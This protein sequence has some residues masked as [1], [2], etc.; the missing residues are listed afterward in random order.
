MKKIYI[1]TNNPIFVK[2][3]WKN[4]KSNLPELY[5]VSYFELNEAGDYVVLVS[6]MNGNRLNEP[7]RLRNDLID[8]INDKIDVS[9][10]IKRL[11]T[12]T[13]IKSYEVLQPSKERMRNINKV[14][15]GLDFS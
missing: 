9:K 6:V 13:Q 4:R 10:Y 7:L 5:I 8:V 11:C 14:I 12:S 3:T 1:D 2:V 15:N